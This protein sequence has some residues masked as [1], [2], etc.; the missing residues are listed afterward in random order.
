MHE[1]NLID[2]PLEDRYLV[3]GSRNKGACIVRSYCTER[4]MLRHQKRRDPTVLLCSL[5]AVSIEGDDT[6]TRKIVAAIEFLAIAY[7]LDETTRRVATL[8]YTYKR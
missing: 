7:F 1:T 8:T 3:S 6:S 5:H 2:D 4:N